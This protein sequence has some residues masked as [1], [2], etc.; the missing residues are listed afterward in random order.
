MTRSRPRPTT[1]HNAR[2][3][4]GVSVV[5]VLALLVGSVAAADTAEDIAQAETELAELESRAETL[6]RRI[7]DGRARHAELE[8][9][10]ATLTDARTLIEIDFASALADLEDS[11]VRLYMDVAAGEGVAAMLMSSD[12][13]Y[14]AAIQYLSTVA[15]DSE[16]A[17]NRLT[18]IASELERRRA[19]LTMALDEQA[20]TDSELAALAAEVTLALDQQT[21]RLERL[22]EL[23]AQE[24]FLAT[25][26]TTTSTT[27]TLPP[28]STT[29]T[30]T[31]TTTVP[32]ETT[33][34]STTTST[35]TTTTSTSTTTT[36]LA[37]TTTTT[38]PPTS[39][40][41]GGGA[42]PVTGAVTFVD[43]WGAPR[44]GGRSHQG[45]DMIASRGTPLAAIYSGV[46]Q[47]TSSS[48][49]GGVS[50]WMESNAGDVFYYAHLE[51]HADGIAPGVAVSEGQTIG[52]N[53]SS[54]NAPDYLPH[55][56]FEY[57]PG[58]GGAVNPYPLVK[59]ICG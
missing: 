30:A 3:A 1:S 9:R 49:L 33:T 28:T 17:L 24:L 29:S 15:D 4:A 11:A 13:V 2:R 41:S 43:S 36:T 31:S 50:I 35:S 7:E 51:A 34:A 26:T 25:S 6:A 38:A 58:G 55:L 22:E 52:Y 53:G 5:L 10:V 42:C 47:R 20:E 56:H 39:A 16:N 8:A 59:S 32:S 57:H 23:R 12:E 18:A 54:G 37:P 45:V 19:E 21:G 14:A 48:T 27:T 44:S 46:I 40:P